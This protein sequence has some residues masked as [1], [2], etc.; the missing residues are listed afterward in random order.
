M[1]FCSE[2]YH[3]T[4]RVRCCVIRLIGHAGNLVD[5]LSR[6]HSDD[7]VVGGLNIKHPHRFCATTVAHGDA[8]KVPVAAFILDREKAP[9]G[10]FLTLIPPTRSMEVEAASAGL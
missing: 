8:K 1:Q 6:R 5:D 4:G 9:I 3:P 10:V 2:F 7:L